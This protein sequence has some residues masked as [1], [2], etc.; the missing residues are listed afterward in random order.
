MAYGPDTDELLRRVAAA[1]NGMLDVGDLEITGLPPLPDGLVTLY[2]DGSGLTELPPLPPGLLELYV[3]GT[4]LQS[5]PPLPESLQVLDIDETPLTNLPP[6]PPDLRYLFTSGTKLTELPPFPP[7]LQKLFISHTP[8]AE[9]PS[10]P[11]SLQYLFCRNTLLRHLPPLPIHLRTLKTVGSPLVFHRADGETIMDYNARWDAWREIQ[12]QKAV[13]AATAL[14]V[15]ASY[16]DSAV[17]RRRVWY[18]VRRTL[19]QTLRREPTQAEL[20]AHPLEMSVLEEAEYE[21]PTV[22][23]DAD[24]IPTRIRR[25]LRSNPSVSDETLRKVIVESLRHSIGHE[26]TPDD[27]AAATPPVL[28]PCL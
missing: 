12:R 24:S 26:P 9:L 21:F 19:R 4:P 28:R 2:A 16:A 6:L 14:A 11:P 5:L 1:A 3:S 22:S 27:L 18:L 25:I 23:G 20:D 10:L 15:R 17:F 13:C 7:V 8:I